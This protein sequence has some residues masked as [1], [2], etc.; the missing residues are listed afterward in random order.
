[1]EPLLSNRILE[2]C[3]SVNEIIRY[4]YNKTYQSVE[5]DV[6]VVLARTVLV[7]SIGSIKDQF[8][9]TASDGIRHSKRNLVETR[10]ACLTRGVDVGKQD[11]AKSSDSVEKESKK[12]LTHGSSSRDDQG[13]ELEILNDQVQ[14]G[15]RCA[16][17]TVVAM[18][19]DAARQVPVPFQLLEVRLHVLGAPRAIASE[20]SNVGPIGIVRKNR[21]ECIVSCASTKST[22]ARIQDTQ[23]LSIL[24]RLATN[25]QATIRLLVCHLR[26]LFLLLEVGV[27]VD[28]VVPAGLLEF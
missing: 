7:D 12:V 10:S 24:G 26:I 6:K 25:V 18:A 22:A 1:M 2:T 17:P 3:K 19:N 23:S 8:T 14:R 13:K 11:V 5:L 28:E 4:Q 27:V 15:Q 16:E 9:G 21:D 20:S